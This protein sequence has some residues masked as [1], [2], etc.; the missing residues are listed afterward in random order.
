M[1]R[2]RRAF[3]I[4]V[5]L[6]PLLLLLAFAATGVQVV[7]RYL[8]PAAPAALLLGVAS[9]RT[10]ARGRAAPRRVAAALALFLGVHAA[11]GLAVTFRA[12]LPSAREHAAGLRASLGEIGRWAARETSPGT[13][14]AVSDIGAFAYYSDRPVL[15]LFGL[16]TPAMGPVAVKAGYDRVVFDLAFESVGRPRYL[17]DRARTRARLTSVPSPENPYRFLFA[18]SIGNLG[19]TR[20][21]GWSYSVYAIDWGVYDRHHPRFAAR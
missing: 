7:S 15:D 9:F 12:S 17:I 13:L 1:P 3:W 20:P 4:L 6:W 10:L 5:A 14:F 18:R 16:V 2:G 19:I 21:G 11:E 8:L